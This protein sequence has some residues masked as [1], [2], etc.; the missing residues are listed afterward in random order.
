MSF[1]AKNNGK[2]K[3]PAGSHSALDV[4][5]EA[6][7]ENQNDIRLQDLSKKVSL[8]RGAGIP[9]LPSLTLTPPPLQY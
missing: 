7:L 8:L 2:G 6:V 4:R 9:Q 3:V 1:Q 5:N